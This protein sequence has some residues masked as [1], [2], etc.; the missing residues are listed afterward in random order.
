MRTRRLPLPPAT[1]LAVGCVALLWTLAATLPAPAEAADT[2]KSDSPDFDPGLCESRF[3]RLRE[4]GQI[5]SPLIAALPDPLDSHFGR[6]FDA[7][8]A[9]VAHALGRSGYIQDLHCLPWSTDKD[10]EPVYRER[11]G[12]V[13]FR[14]NAP[15]RALAVLVVGET[16]LAG[17]HSQAMGRALEL[18]RGR[19]AA[20]APDPK[21]G[22]RD[23]QVVKVLG[24][25]F[26]GSAPSLNLALTVWRRELLDDWEVERTASGKGCKKAKTDDPEI[27]GAR[28]VV[29]IRSGS[30]TADD[31][32]DVLRQG[33]DGDPQFEIEEFEL[34]SASNLDQLSCVWNKLMP[35]R[36]GMKTRLTGRLAKQLPED[37]PCAPDEGQSAEDN[38]RVALLVE[39]SAYGRDFEESGFHVELFPMHS[40]R[41]REIYEKS[42]ASKKQTDSGSKAATEGT[43]LVLSRRP[44]GIP[45]F[46]DEATL[47]SQEMILN[48]I[49]QDLAR[50]RFEVVGVVASDVMDRR[51][52]LERIQ[53]VAPGSRVVTFE[54][55]VLL[56]QVR[57]ASSPAGVLVASSFPLA[58]P[59]PENR[60][61]QPAEDGA[62]PGSEGAPEV[63]EQAGRSDSAPRFP[64]DAAQGVF[65]ATRDLVAGASGAPPMAVRLSIIGNG[66]LHTL[67]RVPLEEP[68]RQGRPE[69]E[70]GDPDPLQA[71]QLLMLR[72]RRLPRGWWYILSLLTVT[73]L[74]AMA[75]VVRCVWP[76]R[77][78]ASEGS[79]S[80]ADG[81]QGKSGKQAF[82][83]GV[84]P[85]ELIK[86]PKWKGCGALS[87]SSDRVL[88]ALVVLVPVV[89][90]VPY[91]I[92]SVPAL[93]GPIRGFVPP[94]GY[95]S[96]MEGPWAEAL[97]PVVIVILVLALVYLLL[98]L[99]TR[100]LWDLTRPRTTAGDSGSRR[101]SWLREALGVVLPLFLT[102]AG[103]LGATLLGGVWI[104]QSWFTEHGD[105]L[106]GRSLALSSGV[107]PLLPS[108]LL[109]GVLVGWIVLSLF[110]HRVRR[111]IPSREEIDELASRGV[112][113]SLLG[114]ICGLRRSIEPASFGQ[115]GG[116]FWSLLIA[117]P[118]FYLVFFYE[119]FLNPPLRSVEG[120]PFDWAT[121]VLFWLTVVVVV[122]A[123]LSL[124]RGWSALRRLLEWLRQSDGAGVEEDRWLDRIRK[125]YSEA[126]DSKVVAETQRRAALTSLWA[127]LRGAQTNVAASDLAERLRS[128]AHDTEDEPA[129]R[130]L[131]IAGW[132]SS[133]ESQLRAAR[134]PLL[135]VRE[136][137]R[138][139]FVWSVVR[140]VRDAYMQLL[141]IMGFMT[142]GALLLL[143]AVTAYPFEPRRILLLYVSSLVALA[144]TLSVWVV[145]QARGDRVLGALEGGQATPW[146]L[147]ASR[148]GVYAGLPAVS[149]LASRFPDLRRVFLDWA[150]PLFE[151]FR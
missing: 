83:F 6:E 80:Q 144:A 55:D 66:A 134:G 148:L 113:K 73:Y 95:R 149:V 105:L 59:D 151:A 125:A 74:L 42:Q 28:M 20:D 16:P 44:H 140:F 50:R 137:A 5:E 93:V 4:W 139:F 52:L 145:L 102:L 38:D 84:I 71:S 150:G 10:A 40:W 119:S 143:L 65:Y 46:G 33:L 87:R 34:L 99:G 60:P 70:A 31:V 54:G 7:L 27:P 123:G 122:G 86:P 72:P 61:D 14:A 25:T 69:V 32:G 18:A 131:T 109:G 26:S 146:K 82:I 39:S 68:P 88:H 51:F 104:R 11:P 89:L 138:D 107:S 116:P 41:L 24:P 129:G 108:L 45:A 9:A 101:P 92:L 3:D 103:I 57:N 126:G 142:I 1:G 136:A 118:A 63:A 49:L 120:V 130:W 36:L 37:H 114:Q 56:S 35:H 121:S 85:V 128:V 147:L 48:G 117:A 111:A 47:A 76:R 13:L 112:E 106:I 30:A 133:S 96:G 17:V 110:R 97:P 100:T 135:E 75:H 23:A 62:E 43:D 81:G 19:F 94:D 78:A 12:I 115:G 79:D 127:A 53:A 141:Q 77:P 124:F 22:T 21:G 132:R 98:G 15:D 90:G 64:F 67:A 2:S 58:W 8:L 29:R 91:L